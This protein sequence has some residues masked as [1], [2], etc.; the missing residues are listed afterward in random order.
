MLS[1]Q[2]VRMHLNGDQIR[3]IEKHAMAVRLALQ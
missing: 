3:A 2:Q 1:Q